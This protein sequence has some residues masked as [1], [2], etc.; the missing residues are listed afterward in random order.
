MQVRWVAGDVWGCR[1]GTD[2][3]VVDQVPLPLLGLGSG[4]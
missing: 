2:V 1:V 3:A 4:T